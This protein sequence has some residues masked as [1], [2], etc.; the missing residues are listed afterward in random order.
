MHKFSLLFSSSLWLYVFYVTFV[1]EVQKFYHLS[2]MQLLS[3][4]SHYCL[5][6]PYSCHNQI[7]IPLTMSTFRHYHFEYVDS[8]SFSSSQFL[9]CTT[10]RVIVFKCIN[11]VFTTLLIWNSY[12]YFPLSKPCCSYR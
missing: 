2:L 5:L 4:H 8:F 11:Y 9:R 12:S 1:V 6:F 7:G 3:L 10:D